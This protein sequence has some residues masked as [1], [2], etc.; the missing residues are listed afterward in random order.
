ME[1]EERE[2][3]AVQNVQNVL[4]EWGP[5][6]SLAEAA[7]E[8]GLP[9]A[10]LAQAVREKRLPALQVQPRR[11]LVRVSAVRARIGLHETRGHPRN[12]KARD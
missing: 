11:W 9:L 7:R 4:D 12:K 8:T 6:V 5:F 2:W 1:A 3:Q 10:T